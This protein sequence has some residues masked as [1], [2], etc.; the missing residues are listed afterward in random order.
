MQQDTDPA[1]FGSVTVKNTP[2]VMLP[3]LPSS[4]DNERVKPFP[5]QIFTL[6]FTLIHQS[7]NE[8]SSSSNN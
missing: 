8:T 2:V 3:Y 5:D 4:K 6:V 1:R 7:S